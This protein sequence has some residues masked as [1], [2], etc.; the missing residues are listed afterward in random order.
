MMYPFENYLKALL[1]KGYGNETISDRI[2]ALRLTVPSHDELDDKRSSVLE[3][4]P[5]YALIYITPGPK[6]N[7]DEFLKGAA[8]AVSFLNIDEMIPVLAGKRD[9]EWE[10]SLLILTDSTLHPLVMSAMLYGSTDQEV[11]DLLFT[12][13]RMVL[14]LRSIALFRKYFWNVDVV[15]KLELYHYISRVVS[16]RNRC[17]FLDAFHK[18]DTQVK[19]KLTGENILKLEDVLAEVMN[20]AFL[21]FKASLSNED[22]ESTNKVIRW[23]ELAMKAAEKYKSATSSQST[24][25]VEALKFQ[26][27]KISQG[28]IKSP[29]K[30]DGDV[31]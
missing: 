3:N 20:E 21:K 30:F 15:T 17:L 24:N 13:H 5:D 25:A 11:V 19:W 10:D 14:T 18:R 28:D 8:S 22:S 31:M 1:I 7:F 27:E 9:P 4:V 12:K 6:Y 26:L 23:A 29:D 2:R 16:P